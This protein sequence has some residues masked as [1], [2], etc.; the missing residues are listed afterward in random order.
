MDVIHQI[1]L[2]QR[3]MPIFQH[4]VEKTIDTIIEATENRLNYIG[5]DKILTNLPM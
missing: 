4:K 1:N 3:K 5:H 2:P